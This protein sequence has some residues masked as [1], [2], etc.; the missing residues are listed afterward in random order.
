MLHPHRDHHGEDR[1]DQPNQGDAM[2]YG[3]APTAGSPPPS[4]A[5]GPV[6]IPAPGKARVARVAQGQGAVSSFNGYAEQEILNQIGFDPLAV[7]MGISVI[8]R[9]GLQ[10]TGLR[11]PTE[12]DVYSRAISMGLL[13]ALGR[14]QQEA[15]EAGADGVIITDVQQQSFDGEE[16]EYSFQG[17]AVRFRPQ[18]GAMRTAGGQPFVSN[19]PLLVLHNM[20]RRGVVP[21]TFGYGVCVYHVPHR[22]LR[23]TIGQTFQN[24]E[25]PVFTEAWY[26][27]RELAIGR[28][29]GQLEQNGAE[30]ILDVSLTTSE[31]AEH[32]TEF[33]VSGQGWA[34][35][36][37]L[38]QH[39]PDL[40]LA[41]IARLEGR[42]AYDL[43]IMYGIAAGRTATT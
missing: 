23:Q 8:H 39:V 25:V 19:S 28:V 12:L 40:D 7:V 36:P 15:A 26:T 2:S 29:H 41:V 11:Q 32:T 24:V 38:E 5:G 22:N 31:H 16:H 14:L 17:T 34:R 18:P 10:V 1:P 4:Q 33:R 21:V 3:S 9:G 43:A 13:N 6:G 35:R 37:E 20:L 27:A 30:M 42:S